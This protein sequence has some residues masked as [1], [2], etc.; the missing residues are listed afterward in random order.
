MEQQVGGVQKHDNSLML[1]RQKLDTLRDLL[2]RE[3]TNLTNLGGDPSG[4]HEHDAYFGLS[5]EGAVQPPQQARLPNTG[6]A[7]HDLGTMLNLAKTF[8]ER[9]LNA[10]SHVEG[11]PNAIISIAGANV[12]LGR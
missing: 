6:I 2:H 5:A 9:R 7:S 11:L 10:P 3:S 12:E 4:G 8:E 1:E